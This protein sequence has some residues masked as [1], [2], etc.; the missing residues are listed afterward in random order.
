MPSPGMG[1]IASLDYTTEE[2]QR[3]AKKSLEFECPECGRTANLLLEPSSASGNENEAV[4]AEAREIAAQ[5]TMKGESNQDPPAHSNSPD[6]TEPAPPPSTPSPPSP[7]VEPAPAIQQQQRIPTSN[8]DVMYNYIIA[9]I[10]V[11]LA[12]LIYRRFVSSAVA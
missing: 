5:V 4:Q 8:S 7:G 3:L 9:A 12:I 1:A 11:M 10:L 2:R 6:V